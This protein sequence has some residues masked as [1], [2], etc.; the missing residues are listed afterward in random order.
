MLDRTIPYYNMILRCDA[1]RSIAAPLP[2]GYSIR[3]FQPG[4]AC[5]WAQMEYEVGDFASPEDAGQYFDKTFRP[6]MDELL[7]R[8]SIA[9]TPDGAPAGSCFAWFGERDGK[10]AASL[11]WLVVSPRF[12]GLGLGKALCAEALRLF[13]QLGEFPVYLHTQPWSWQAIMIYRRQG[14]RLCQ[15][16]TFDGYENQFAQAVETL[17]RVLPESPLD[18]M[19]AEVHA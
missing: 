2:S 12:Q 7:K 14:F 16:D 17:R 18:E 11:H 9:V 19:L 6:H 15:T 8:G 5:A 3:R 10:T 13:E 4:D 1:R